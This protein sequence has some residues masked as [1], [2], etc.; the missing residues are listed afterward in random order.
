[1]RLVFGQDAAV[2]RW[3]ASRT[4]GQ[5]DFGVCTAIGV[6][7][8]NRPIAGVVYHMYAE[9]YRTLMV[10]CAA[11]DARWASRGVVKALLHYPFEQLGVSKLWSVMASSNHRALKFNKGLGFKPEATLSHHFGKD[12]A[13]VT[14][15]FRKDYDR[16]Y[17][18]KVGEEDLR[19]RRA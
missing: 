2:A 7:D 14:R 19:A 18:G 13:I 12:H 9:T 6:A 11:I 3:V 4:P 1:M 5:G 16:L 10:S 8:G 15:M 17:G